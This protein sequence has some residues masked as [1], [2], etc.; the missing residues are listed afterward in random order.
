[1]IP[2][3]VESLVFNLESG[4]LADKDLEVGVNNNNKRVM[5]IS[6]NCINLEG[7]VVTKADADSLLVLKQIRR[8]TSS[9]SSGIAI[10]DH[11]SWGGYWTFGSRR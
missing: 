9:S 3:N 4:S 7:T 11:L 5:T 6:R 8:W 10:R 2:A 1:M